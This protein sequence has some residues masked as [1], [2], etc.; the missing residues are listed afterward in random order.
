MSD[1][2]DLSFCTYELE[3]YATI[4]ERRVYSTLIEEVNFTRNLLCIS[5]E[6]KVLPIVTKEV[7][8]K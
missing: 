8:M 4:L 5:N 2:L 3:P 7:K 6:M 1:Q